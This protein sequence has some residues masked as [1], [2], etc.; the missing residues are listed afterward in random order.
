MLTQNGN[1]RP[2]TA[3]FLHFYG[4]SRPKSAGRGSSTAPPLPFGFAVERSLATA[5]TVLR[6][7]Q[8][9]NL[10]GWRQRRFLGSSLTQTVV[11]PV[12]PPE[13][14]LLPLPPSFPAE[15][16]VH[17]KG[18]PLGERAAFGGFRFGWGSGFLGKP[19]RGGGSRCTNL[20]RVAAQPFPRS[21][22]RPCCTDYVC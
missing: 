16:I 20:S 14:A 11:Q 13:V 21:L 6:S 1:T 7:A 18:G 2:K 22:R 9:Q 5:W 10:S 8:W 17:P 3:E 15:R 4:K 19:K 12:T